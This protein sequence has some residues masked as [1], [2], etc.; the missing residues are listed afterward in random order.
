MDGVVSNEVPFLLPVLKAWSV[1]MVAMATRGWVR[2]D[3]D[4]AVVSLKRNAGLWRVWS[5]GIRSVPYFHSRCVCVLVAVWTD[6]VTRVGI[7]SDIQNDIG[8]QCMATQHWWEWSL[9]I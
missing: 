7:A 3:A 9:E 1:I 5:F 4:V 2:M 6:D 8:D